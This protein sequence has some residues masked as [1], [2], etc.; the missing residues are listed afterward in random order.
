[1]SLE[2]SKCFFRITP[3]IPPNGYVIERPD[4]SLILARWTLI[5]DE[6]AGY[7]LMHTHNR[8]RR[9]TI[10]GRVV[11]RFGN[12]LITWYRK[13]V[14][15]DHRLESLTSKPRRWTF[16]ALF[17]HA[18]E[19]INPPGETHSLRRTSFDPDRIR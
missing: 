7:I 3:Y 4:A 2:P 14:A 17:A 10:A 15:F 19:Y 1:M 8:R 9:D 11:A 6:S 13:K 18:E 12:I 16:I 5:L